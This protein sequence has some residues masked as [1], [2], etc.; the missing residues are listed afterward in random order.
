MAWELRP[1]LLDRAPRTNCHGCP[2][3]LLYFVEFQL[4]IAEPLSRPDPM[5]SPAFVFQDLLTQSVA[6][7]SCRRRVVARSVGLNRQDHPPRL[8]WMRTGKVNAISG[9]A[10]LSRNGDPSSFQAFLYRELEGIERHLTGFC[11][12]FFTARGGE[13]EVLAQE[14]D[15]LGLG[16]A[17]CNVVVGK[18]RNQLQP[19]AGA[20]DRDI[21]A[22]F[23]S[24]LVE[25]P[26]AE[27]QVAVG[28]LVVAEAENDGVSL[29]ALDALD[30]LDEEPL[31]VGLREELVERRVAQIAEALAQDVLDVVRVMLTKGNDSE[32]LA[33]SVASVVQHEIDN[34]LNFVGI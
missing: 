1:L 34:P 5:E 17:R 24:F 25:R 4:A 15:S 18:R 13:L 12:Q 16:A 11:A 2:P 33:R 28:I 22:A 6:V 31:L 32:R 29:V 3:R 8:V 14:F 23:P 19:R 30:V 26:E 7:A 20:A 27:R 10:V 9:D 21:E